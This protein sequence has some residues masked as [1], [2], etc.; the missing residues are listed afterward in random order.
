MNISLKRAVYQA[1]ILAALL[2][3]AR[4]LTAHLEQQGQVFL[5]A[6]P[7]PASVKSAVFPMPA[8]F[9]GFLSDWAFVK[10]DQYFHEGRWNKILP[11][12]RV[13][14]TLTPAETEAWSTGAWHLAFNLS[15]AAQDPLE[16]ARLKQLGF[17]FLHEGVRRHPDVAHLYFD[18]G[19][20][21]AKRYANVEEALRNFKMALS[22]HYERRSVTWVAYLLNRHHRYAEEAEVWT[23]YL[24]LFPNDEGARNHLTKASEA[25][26]SIKEAQ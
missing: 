13:R 19:W 6:S 18:L 15:D 23:K 7:L 14:A 8:E 1:F 9:R 17:D 20:M 25:A 2:G 16:K 12:L 10:S 24:K 4:L 26:K 21:Y 3:A 22:L 5:D 11:L